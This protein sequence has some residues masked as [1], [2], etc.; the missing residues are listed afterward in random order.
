MDRFARSLE[1]FNWMFFVDWPIATITS[2]SGSSKAVNS[3]WTRRLL[4]LILCCLIP[5][6]VASVRAQDA[7]LEPLDIQIVEA[8]WGFDGFSRY[9]TFVPL[10]I[11]IRNRSATQRTL[12]LRLSREDSIQSV[13]ESLEKEVSLSAETTRVVQMTPFVSDPGDTW[14][15][16]WGPTEAESLS[17]K[18]DSADDGVVFIVSSSTSSFRTG[19][20]P[21]MRDDE[22]PTSI[23][24]LDALRVVLLD[25][26]PRWTGGRKK[27]FQEWL[28]KGGKVVVLDNINGTTTKFSNGFEFLNLTKSEVRYG[29]G[30]IQKLALPAE[31]VTREVIEKQI[32]HRELTGGNLE[33]K[34]KAYASMT[35][36]R[37]FRSAGGTYEQKPVYYTRDK[38]LSELKELAK[39]RQQWGLIYLAVFAYVGWQWRVGW[40]WGLMEKQPGRFYAWMLGL[41]LGFSVIFLSYG[42]I[43]TKGSDRVVTVAV[44]RQLSEGIYDVE[45]WA[46][47]GIG[48]NGGEHRFAVNGTG[49]LYG[50]AESFSQNPMRIQDTEMT[51]DLTAF[52]TQKVAFRTRL[53]MPDIPLQLMGDDLEL[54]QSQSVE[55]TIDPTYKAPVYAALVAID[56][57]IYEFTSR[58]GK[59]VPAEAPVNTILGMLDP[60]SIR[61]MQRSSWQKLLVYWLFDMKSAEKSYEDAFYDVIGNGY[62]VGSTIFPDSFDIPKGVARVMIYTD[63]PASLK[64][65]GDFPDQAGRMLYVTDIPLKGVR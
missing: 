53:E 44:A 45:G 37:A 8:K 55:L 24:Q 59:L 27:S 64:L 20:L 54:L 1:P 50:G 2:L 49:Q 13:G 61:N 11:V 48:L 38:V 57:K 34:L 62:S 3:M 52:S 22:F 29:A 35:D 7:S 18:S 43:G 47:L 63:L 28:L 9:K 51:V 14:T 4:I 39:T 23:T 36:V 17:I 5:F 30:V 26:E 56:N 46:V 42:H 16:R 33:Q 19:S 31:Q 12:Q 10:R 21:I 65:T 60:N 6:A 32:L 40:R 41:A 25:S 58:S 15:L